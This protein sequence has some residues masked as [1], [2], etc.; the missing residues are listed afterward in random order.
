[1]KKI[2]IL[3]TM[4]IFVA[5]FAGK[6]I[7]QS[8]PFPNSDGKTIYYSIITSTTVEVTDS[9]SYTPYGYRGKLV[10][11]DTV[12]YNNTYYSVV[13]IGLSAFQGCKELDSVIL[14]NTLTYIDSLAFSGCTKLSE[15]IIP[16]SVTMIGSSAFSDCTNLTLVT[17]GNSVKTIRN[18]VFQGCSKLSE[19]TIPNSVTTIGSSAFSTCTKLSALTIGSSVETIGYR[20]FSRCLYLTSVSIPASVTTI[21]RGIFAECDK[22]TVIEV[23]ANNPA[24]CSVDG[25]LFDKTQTVL[26]ECPAAQT[27]RYIIP[28]TVTSIATDAFY[29]CTKLTAVLIPNLVATIGDYAFADCFGLKEIYVKTPAPPQIQSA[30][31][32]DDAFQIVTV[33]V[34]G[35]VEN[36]KAADYWKNFKKII[37][38]C[39]AN[40]IDNVSFK[41]DITIYPNPVRDN[42]RVMLPENIHQAVF[43]LYDMQGRTLIHQNITNH[44]IVTLNNFAE[45]I[46]LYNI[47]T[48]KQQY[49]G[50][51]LKR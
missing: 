46:Y 25:V 27:G 16:D 7:A 11:P 14:P 19:I 8:F 3:S 17:I 44:D 29:A 48:D 5:L 26:V 9:S 6:A 30:T 41:D 1:M 38:D 13:S 40:S 51:I 24:Y 4:C 47:T 12:E 18:T 20:A 22:L 36:Y 45:G 28:N 42:I 32:D 34:C 23:D 50:K 39:D 37:E 43:R 49:Q 21:G 10:I 35:S 2:I 15:I 33:Y 31:F